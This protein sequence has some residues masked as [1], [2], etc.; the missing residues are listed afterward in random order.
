M[1][2]EEISWISRVFRKVDVFST[3]TVGEMSNLID[4]MKEYHFTKGQ[5]VVKQGE[6]GDAF[7]IIYKGKA[8][9]RFFQN[10]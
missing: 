3:L 7:Y 5:K 10:R 8:K 6:K 9:K 4:F 1:G 2:P